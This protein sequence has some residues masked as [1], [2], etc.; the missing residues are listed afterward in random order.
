MYLQASLRFVIIL[1][2]VSQSLWTK[3]LAVMPLNFFPQYQKTIPVKQKKVIRA[4]LVNIGGMKPLA[5]D[6]GVMNL[7]NP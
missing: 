7:L 2:K 4:M 3:D 1:P 5:S 6:Q